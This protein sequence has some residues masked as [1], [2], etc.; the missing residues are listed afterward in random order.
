MP[1]FALD[2]AL[3]LI[4]REKPTIMPCVPTLLNAIMSH[5]KIKS[6]DS[7]CKLPQSAVKFA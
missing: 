7:P 6:F 5:P 1:R 2:D 4:D 3:K